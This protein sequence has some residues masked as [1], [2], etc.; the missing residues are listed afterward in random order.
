MINGF[1]KK[2]DVQKTKKNWNVKTHRHKIYTQKSTN[3]VDK[4]I[5][6]KNIILTPIPTSTSQRQQQSLDHLRRK[7]KQN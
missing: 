5:E 7:T 1:S 6:I 3:T 2:F 4:L